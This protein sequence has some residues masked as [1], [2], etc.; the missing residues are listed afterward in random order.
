M[1]V[2]NVLTF[3]K[4]TFIENK[5]QRIKAKH[6]DLGSFWMRRSNNIIAL[7]LA[8]AMKKNITHQ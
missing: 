4:E 3:R 6:E 8:I 2:S 7:S 1:K 5:S